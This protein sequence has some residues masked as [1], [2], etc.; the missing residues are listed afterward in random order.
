MKFK[1]RWQAAAWL[2]ALAGLGAPAAPL[3]SGERLPAD[4]PGL[5]LWWALSS[6]AKIQPSTPAPEQPGRAITLHSA[7]NEYEAACL[8]VNPARSLTGVSVSAGPL[9]GPGGGV[10][11]AKHLEF[12]QVRY[13]QI[14]QATDRH[15]QPGWWPDPLLP[16]EGPLNLGAGSNH[17]FWIRV[18]VPKETP[19]GAYRGVVRLAAA[20]CTAEAPLELVVYDFTLPDRM[21]CTTAFGFSA[22]EVFRYHGLKTDPDKRLVLDKYL[23]NLAA[24]HV[25]PYDPA[26]LDRF[27]VRWPDVRPPRSPWDDW[28]GLRIVTNEVHSGR[29]ALL[30]YDDKPGEN[31]TVTYEPLIPIPEKGFGFRAWFRT[32]VPGHRFILS[33]NHYDANRQWMSGRNND[34]AFAGTGQWQAIEERLTR[35]PEGAAFVRLHLRATVW[36]DAGEPVGLVWFDDLSLTDLGT[37]GECL[38]GGDFERRPRTEPVVAA[39]KLKVEFDFRD[40]DRA[41]ERAM[42]T[43]HFNSFQ[44]PFPGLGGGTFHEIDPPSLLG[45]RED[46][47]EYPL[48]M[49]S[50]GSQLEAHLRERGWLDKAFVYW[51]DEPSPDQYPFV[52]NGFAKLKRY[53]PGLT[54]MLTEQVEPGLVGGPNLWCPISNEFQP[55]RAAERQALGEKFWWYVC[56]GP[57]APYAGLFIDHPAPEMRIWVWQTWQRGINGLLVWQINYWTSSAAYP[58]RGRPQNPYEDPMSWTSG[59]ST[60]AGKR[61]PWGNGDGRFLYPPLAAASANP[62][63]P[64]LAGPVDS[65]RWEHLRDG[66]EDYEYLCLL[67]QRLEQHKRRLS[68]ADLA[69]FA[70]LLEVPETITRTLTQFAPDGAPIEAHRR[71]VGRALEKLGR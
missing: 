48:L 68:A 42:N 46:D 70:K 3:V 33:F 2:L 26:P 61:L 34:L 31:V 54:R 30:V 57:K 14:T 58:D 38:A 43:Y 13:L 71:A 47:P 7:R 12:L 40:W 49:A 18:F 51:F 29:G 15:S 25:S 5:T 21:T 4:A 55:D 56:T 36:T 22:G 67:R 10:L 17:V 66:I 44:V 50:Y 23:A 53:A 32:A 9:A 24:H 28:A 39:E 35:F 16:I 45:F 19:A 65:I 41:M 69:A 52:M 20:E 62:P 11:P 1:L 6:A 8:V 37:G 27:K 64:V 63:A 59:Y 60:P